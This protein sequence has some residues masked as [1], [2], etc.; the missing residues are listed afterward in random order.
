MSKNIKPQTTFSILIRLALLFVFAMVS[1]TI[2]ADATVGSQAPDLGVIDVNG[3]V[4]KLSEF[5][6]KFVVLEWVNPD[7]PF[8]KK[9]YDS[10]NMQS[11]QKKYTNK[12]I[13][14][15]SINSS[16]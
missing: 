10:K 13:V 9:H 14:W 3:K 5:Q 7:C 1:T 11:L 4:R 15:L 6:G 2:F 8:V 12:G 16:A